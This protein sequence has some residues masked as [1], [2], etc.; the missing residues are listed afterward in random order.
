VEQGS[1]VSAWSRATS[2][3]VIV[4]R[5]IQ[6]NMFTYPPS[7]PI[8][9]GDNL[10]SDGHG[11][12]PT[13][14]SD[15]SIGKR[16]QIHLLEILR[17]FDSILL[18]LSKFSSTSEAAGGGARSAIGDLGGD[19]DILTQGLI[20]LIEY[21]YHQGIPSFSEAQLKRTPRLS[22]LDPEQF[23]FRMGDR[24]GSLPGCTQVRTKVCRKD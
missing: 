12:L 5:I 4:P 16:E 17:R 22:V 21:S 23:H 7:P 1:V 6:F 3:I 14:N 15:T 9:I 20:G 24:S 11:L 2:I 10:V 8:H 19:C 18:K 13:M